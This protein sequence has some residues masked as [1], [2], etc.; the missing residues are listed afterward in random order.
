MRSPFAPV[1]L[2]LVAL[3]ASLVRW[4]VQGSGNLYT[5]VAKR[6]YV[7]DPDLGW[8]IAPEHPVWLGLE[9]C[10]IIAAIAI[11]LAVGGLVIRKLETR[12]GTPHR[13]LRLAAWAV[14]AVP[15]I[16]PVVAFS[17]GGAPAGARDVLPAARAVALEEG[18]Q[19][20]IDLPAGTY[21]VVAH[22]GNAITAKLTAGGEAFEARFSGDVAGSI[23]ID[24]RALG[25]QTTGEVSVATA[26][27]DTGIGE[28]SKHAREGYLL[29]T[30]HPRLTFTLGTLIA[31]R[32][33][34]PN[35][36]AFRALGTVTLIGR[37]H[38]V[39]VIGTLSRPDAAGLARLGLTGD[40]LIVNAQ[41]SL[42][43]KDTALAPDAADFDGDLIPV[44][45][46]LMLRRNPLPGKSI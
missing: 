42:R 13:V 7:P 2:A 33:D 46:T 8:K 45:V 10:A 16:V 23:T 22:S 38:P 19:G 4:A 27:V 44:N 32:Q 43:I 26:S 9:V 6:F 40:V 21:A 18:V 3:T 14:A 20:S 41:L 5:A 28:R 11:G 12:R 35:T 31:A 1:L 30:A 37:T 24:P 34:T 25:T 15:L 17:S 39:E 29:A 36:V